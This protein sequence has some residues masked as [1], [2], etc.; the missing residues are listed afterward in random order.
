LAA[1]GNHEG[2]CWC[3]AVTPAPEA[4]RRVPPELRHKVCLCRECLSR[5]QWPETTAARVPASGTAP[6][7]KS[8]VAS[9]LLALSLAG[10]Q[11]AT[12]TED[13]STNPTARGWSVFG[14]TNLFR[15][16]AAAG[17]LEVTWDSRRTNSYFRHPA[18]TIL[19]KQDSF[20]FSFDLR[21]ADAVIGIDPA[22]PYS[23]EVAL[24]FQNSHSATNANFQRGRGYGAAPNLVE[25]DYFPEYFNPDDQF[26]HQ[27]TVW[28]GIVATN[29]AFNYDS[30]NSYLEITLPAN[31]WLRV[32]MNYDAATRRLATTLRTNAQPFAT[33]LEGAQLAQFSVQVMT[34]FSDYRVD[35]FSISSYND[36]G[37]T[38]SLLAHGLVDNVS[39]TVPDPP[40][41][42]ITALANGQAG[43]YALTNWLYCLERTE[44]FLTWQKA[45]P[46]V[47]GTGGWQ[48]LTATNLF[49][50]AGFYRL[51]AERP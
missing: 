43:F 35:A 48:V 45:S 28:P 5:E 15:W 49:I 41:T 8:L 6:C 38:G 13:F 37:G 10:L 14:D 46:S 23:F 20:A 31:L 3:W 30:A 11:A 1:R 36:T 12:F 44:N 9:L 21:L 47:P 42:Q 32:T 2:P 24:G 40:V 16:N 4:L 27:A 19:G 17:N 50:G 34:N 29:G 18:Q 25:F 26:S 39:W 7:H 22:K 33:G 51:A